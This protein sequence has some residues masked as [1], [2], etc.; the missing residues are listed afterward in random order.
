M[1]EAEVELRHQVCWAYAL[2]SSFW[3]LWPAEVR[4]VRQDRAP[5]R[6]GVG[7]ERE[8]RQQ[9]V[10]SS[11]G[12]GRWSIVFTHS[13]L[14]LC[15]VLLTTKVPKGDKFITA[16]PWNA[17]LVDHKAEA[18]RKEMLGLLPNATVWEVGGTGWRASVEQLGLEMSNE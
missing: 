13:L 16:F 12:K 4:V 15:L 9:R 10:G 7:N 3:R 17:S 5:R 6:E 18:V 1:V 8:M 2:L 11:S 14:G